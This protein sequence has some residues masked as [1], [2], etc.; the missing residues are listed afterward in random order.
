MISFDP[1]VVPAMMIQ[2]QVKSVH[3][4]PGVHEAAS[5]SLFSSA[6]LVLDCCNV[7]G[8]LPEGSCQSRAR[9]P[10]PGPAD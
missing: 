9:R 3:S 2:I 7:A 6:S 8:Q 5:D 10:D 1:C 4:K